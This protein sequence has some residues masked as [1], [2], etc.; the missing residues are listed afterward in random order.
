MLASKCIQRIDTVRT[1]SDFCDG[2]EENDMACFINWDLRGQACRLRPHPSRLTPCHLPPRGKVL[3]SRG[4]GY[5][6]SF[7][8]TVYSSRI[9]CSETSKGTMRRFCRGVLPLWR[10]FK[11]SLCNR[12]APDA[13]A[14]T[15][16]QENRGGPGGSCFCFPPGGFVRAGR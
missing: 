6:H 12:A 15:P 7:Q 4:P 13:A 2:W 9:G 10:K 1:N 14:T 16:T 3:K 11:E 5:S 8:T